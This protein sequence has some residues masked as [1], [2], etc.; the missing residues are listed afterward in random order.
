MLISHLFETLC[1]NSQKKSILARFL[2]FKTIFSETRT[3]DLWSYNTYVCLIVT[4]CNL[5]KSTNTGKDCIYMMRNGRICNTHIE[6]QPSR[7]LIKSG[8]NTD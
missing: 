4:V 8:Q 1:T 3:D 5:R 2:Y 7:L 6:M